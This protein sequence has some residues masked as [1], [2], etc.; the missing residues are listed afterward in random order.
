MTGAMGTLGILVDLSLKCLP[1]PRTQ[2]TLVSEASASEAIKR[3]NQ[4]GGKPL[5]ISATCHYAGHLYVRLSGA[6]PAVE[7]ATRTLG[8]TSL[9]NDNAFWCSVR[10]QTLAPL[11]E[12]RELWRLSIAST[13]P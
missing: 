6:A 3:M 12:A 13:A 9:E 5:P 7:A 10:E 4:W 8:G 1:L 11:A 2:V